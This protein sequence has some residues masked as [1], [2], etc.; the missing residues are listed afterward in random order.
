MI[1][2]FFS[3]ENLFLQIQYEIFKLCNNYPEKQSV[4]NILNS[5]GTV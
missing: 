4:Q 1:Y 3:S 5:F 2:K